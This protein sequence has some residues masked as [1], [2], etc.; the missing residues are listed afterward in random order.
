LE[1]GIQ[2]RCQAK[3]HGKLLSFVTADVT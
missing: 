3:Y 1:F 2:L